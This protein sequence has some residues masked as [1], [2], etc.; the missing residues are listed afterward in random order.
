MGGASS[1]ETNLGTDL[2]DDNWSSP[3]PE[4]DPSDEDYIPSEGSSDVSLT[5]DPPSITLRGTSNHRI[6]DYHYSRG[7]RY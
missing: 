3:S 1:D 6:R 7:F 5:D 4:T 2:S